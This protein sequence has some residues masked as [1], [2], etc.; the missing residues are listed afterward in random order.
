MRWLDQVVGDAICFGLARFRMGRRS[1]RGV[2]K[3][4]GPVLFIGLA[5]MGSTLLADPAMSRA[6]DYCGAAPHFAIFS[7]NRD[8]L[9][10]TGTVP[11]ENVFC[12]RTDNL[13]TLAIDTVRFMGWA[14]R[15]GIGVAVDTD[16]CSNF[17]AIL[18]F[19]SG[20]SRRAGFH[21]A[22][23]NGRGALFNCGALYRTELHL[24]HNLIRLTDAALDS[25]KDRKT[26]R[27]SPFLPA[28]PQRKIL[29]AERLA[30]QARLQALAPDF[31]PARHRILLVNPNVGDLVP[32]RRWPRGS[33][34]ELINRILGRHPDLFVL[35]LGAGADAA[36]VKGLEEEVGDRRCRT[37]AGAF[38][39]AELPV[40]FDSSALLLSS[41]SGPAHFASVT[42]LP[43]VV[44]FGP[45]TPA[46]YLPLGNATALV[47]GVECSPCITPDNHRRVDCRDNHCMRNI[48]VA[49]VLAEV[50]RRL[51]G[52]ALQV[53]GSRQGGVRR[54]IGGGLTPE[55]AQAG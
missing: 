55:A 19:L 11:P 22:F 7:Q 53:V 39:L 43:V 5:E 30:L 14:R 8:S 33:F 42:S 31:D 1:A 4:S 15:R 48:S 35:L 37:I 29:P 44:L 34:V 23:N 47:A 32:Q 27:S 46:R 10:F 9:R 20:A 28:V 18:A 6:R 40:L 50:E 13:L 25:G 26:S 24:A 41:D 36:S 2:G 45:E 12:L 54:G 21:H 49:T 52:S 17:S 51:A 38:A 16:P 3:A